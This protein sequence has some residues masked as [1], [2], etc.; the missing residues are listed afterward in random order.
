MDVIKLWSNHST[1]PA[2]MMV[3]HA[4]PFSKQKHWPEQLPLLSFIP[5]SIPNHLT[6]QSRMKV[7]LQMSP[8]VM[9]KSSIL[10]ASWSVKVF[11]SQS[12]QGPS[13]AFC[14]RSSSLLLLMNL[15]NKAKKACLR[16]IGRTNFSVGRVYFCVANYLP[17]FSHCL[18]DSC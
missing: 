9:Q 11:I 3:R 16:K 18:N 14:S 13:S 4:I 5:F 8:I 12:W 2:R 15:E 6:L 7:I 10:A 1:F 17:T